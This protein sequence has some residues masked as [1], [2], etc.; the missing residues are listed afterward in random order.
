MSIVKSTSSG[1]HAKITQAYLETNGYKKKNEQGWAALTDNWYKDDEHYITFLQLENVYAVDFDGPEDPNSKLPIK[2]RWKF[3]TIGDLILV[4]R[5]WFGVP[6]A[7]KL[8]RKKMMETAEPL[9]VTA[10]KEI[11]A[12]T[13][14]STLVPVTPMDTPTCKT[15]WID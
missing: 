7:S 13:I 4:E 5:L 3:S 10:A 8:A 12:K 2:Y 11:F 6:L 14:G 9:F 1:I 15:L